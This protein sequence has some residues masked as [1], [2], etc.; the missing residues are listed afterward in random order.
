MKGTV[1]AI[2]AGGDVSLIEGSLK[3]AE[4]DSVC[5]EYKKGSV[6]IGH[7]FYTLGGGFTPWTP[8]FPQ[9][10]LTLAHGIGDVLEGTEGRQWGGG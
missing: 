1:T 4:A 9:M 8:N 7:L 2:L 10:D 3:G 6:V 5:T